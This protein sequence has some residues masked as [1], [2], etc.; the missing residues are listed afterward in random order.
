MEAV[1]RGWRRF[2]RLPIAAQA[3]AWL[4]L[5]G[6]Y[7][8]VLI[9]VFAGGNGESEATPP[10]GV[11]RA[12]ERSE[13]EARVA[14]FVTAVKPKVAEDTDVAEFRKPRLRSVECG[15]DA[16]TIA[17][18]SG[19]PGEGR[20]LEDQRQVWERIFRETE[21]RRATVRV[22]RAASV[23]AGTQA[24]A[25]EETEPGR[26]LVETTCDR[27]RKPE[28]DWSRHSG[29]EILEGICTASAFS[30][31]RGE[32]GAGRPVSPRGN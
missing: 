28:V 13:L 3:A 23:G 20:I 22:Y 24:K 5:A 11:Q 10:G 32:G 16:C 4:L 19:L 29:L 17:Y 8:G 26:L 12:S 27:G 18:H 9:V 25:E 15:D 14:G 30:A 6:V 31:G 1:G 2:R 7:T 21:L